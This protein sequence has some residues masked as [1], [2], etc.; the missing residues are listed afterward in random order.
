MMPR[1]EEQ[2]EPPV[3]HRMKCL[4]TAKLFAEMPDMEVGSIV[5]SE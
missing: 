4:P 1:W 2:K 3:C 5:L